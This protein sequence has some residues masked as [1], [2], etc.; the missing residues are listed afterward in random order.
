MARKKDF[1]TADGAVDKFFTPRSNDQDTHDTN[2][3][4]NAKDT[5]NTKVDNNTK[6]TNKSKHYNE[7]GRRAERFGL[8][9]D[10]Q[11]KTDITHLSKATDSKSVNDFIVT[12]LLEHVVRP[13]SQAKLKQYRKLLQG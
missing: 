3:A 2:D 11:L 6:T 5:K 13:E 7:R 10:E 4:H 9:L 1:T 8:L 12:V